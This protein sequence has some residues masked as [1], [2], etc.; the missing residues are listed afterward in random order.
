VRAQV[1]SD[2]KL[3][4][5]LQE[6]TALF[7]LMRRA[8]EVEA[9]PAMRATVLA[10]ARK[11]T[12]PTLWQRVRRL[13]SLAT[14]RFRHSMGF[15]I[16]AISLGAHLVAMATLFWAMEHRDREQRKSQLVAVVTEPELEAQR[17]DSS[18]ASRLAQRQLPHETRL[19]QFGVEGQQGAIE[20]GLRAL[21]Q[22]QGDDGSFGDVTVTAQATLAL[23]AEGDSSAQTTRRGVAIDR[24]MSWLLDAARRGASDGALLAALVEDYSLAYA[25]M[26]DERRLE[27]TRAIRELIQSVSAAD[28]MA[29]ESLVLAKMAGFYVPSARPLGRAALLEAGDRAALL[30]APAD[31][32][33]A[34]IVLARGRLSVQ[35]SRV[36]AWSRDLFDRAVKEIE[37]GNRSGLVLLT[38]QA[39]Y[40]L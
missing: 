8:D 10:A 25:D 30:D 3:A 28:P 15:R 31:R 16:A 19:R 18:F 38:L 26:S 21:L 34:T 23:L 20:R 36:K 17:P 40:R 9:S 39:P 4:R 5:E 32:F 14:F 37:A 35:R 6:L 22:D 7:G 24:A 13:P 1:R 2:P 29:Q 11:A 27:Y 12:R 33:G